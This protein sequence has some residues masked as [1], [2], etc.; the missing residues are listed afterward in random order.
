[1]TPYQI[2]WINTDATEKDIKSAY[3]I[4]V[5]ECH[6][7]LHPDDPRAGEKFI[8]IH[9][10]YQK[11]INWKVSDVLFNQGNNNVF[12]KDKAKKWLSTSEELIFCEDILNSNDK[13]KYYEAFTSLKFAIAHQKLLLRLDEFYDWEK[14]LELAWY[15]RKWNR[16]RGWIEILVIFEEYIINSI[17]N[18]WSQGDY[19]NS[20]KKL[21][22]SVGH[23]KLLQG[24]DDFYDWEQ[25][26]KIASYLK[27]N[28]TKTSGWLE[29]LDSLERHIINSI[30]E[31]GSN[32]DYYECFQ[33]I[34]NYLSYY[35]F[36]K[37][38][39]D[40]YDWEKVLKLVSQ[41]NESWFIFAWNRDY[42]MLLES[43]IIKKV[44]KNK[45]KNTAEQLLGNVWFRMN[46]RSLKKFL[47]KWVLLSKIFKK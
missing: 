9:Q 39:D 28:W 7:D 26:L 17:L 31:N 1:M 6:P 29:V 21:W 45:D 44:I 30:L 20:F 5:K 36:L 27:R 40:F 10:A 34:T 4:L 24:L 22:S 16:V 25:V 38:L 13:D 14:V 47:K 37:R 42:L 23:Q 41:V 35:S 46:E 2:L 12:S 3:R 15:L 43:Y 32:N 8:K 18:N 11:I 19:Y 33:Y